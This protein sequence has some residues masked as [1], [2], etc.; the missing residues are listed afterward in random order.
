LR[1]F[2]EKGEV[3]VGHSPIDKEITIRKAELDDHARIISV[4]PDWWGGRDLRAMVPRVFLM[5]FCDTSLIVEKDGEMV[6]FLIGFLSP[7][8]PDEG[9]IHFVGVHPDYRKL[10]LGA[11]L[12][13]RFFELCRTHGRTTVR[14]C[15]SPVNKGSI[16]F[17]TR[18]GFE[19][20]PGDGEA[21][22]V[23]V[24]RDYNRPGDHKVLFKKIL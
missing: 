14:C 4:I 21:D 24:T 1:M 17:H 9:Y 7:S 12:Y 22:G 5:H 8:R 13:E 10:G 11:T 6:S 19:I 20:L 2:N 3:R 18:M 23:P 16:A 15:T